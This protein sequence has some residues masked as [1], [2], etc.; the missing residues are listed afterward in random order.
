MGR[1]HKKEHSLD[2]LQMLKVKRPP[3]PPH[4]RSPDSILY[5][6]IDKNSDHAE[7]R[8]TVITIANRTL[9]LQN[10]FL[11]YILEG[12]HQIIYFYKAVRP[13]H[14]VYPYYRLIS[15]SLDV[16]MQAYTVSA[17]RLYVT[18]LPPSE[19]T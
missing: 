12:K 8:K 11:S 7:K 10:L 15:L 6:C 19:C 5:N 2:N 13:P 16:C 3:H 18:R 17:N 4:H 9:H 14:F 1:Y